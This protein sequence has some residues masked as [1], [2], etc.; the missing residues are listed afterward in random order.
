MERAW[1]FLLM[2]NKAVPFRMLRFC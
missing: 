2:F 1:F